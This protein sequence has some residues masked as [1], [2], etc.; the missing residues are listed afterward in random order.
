MSDAKFPAG[1]SR[2]SST[3][4]PYKQGLRPQRKPQGFP[5]G[6]RKTPPLTPA[7]H[8]DFFPP[9]GSKRS[10]SGDKGAMWAAAR[11]S[12]AGKL[13]AMGA[14]P[15]SPARK[16]EDR[17]RSV[18]GSSQGT[19]PSQGWGAEQGMKLLRLTMHRGLFDPG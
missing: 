6:L 16:E 12:K 15:G 3:L 11:G 4:L 18:A 7:A 14:E 5:K 17:K 13:S 2:S 10:R 1:D 19:S 9:P 8:C